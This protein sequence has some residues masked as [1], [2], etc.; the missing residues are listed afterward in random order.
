[1]SVDASSVGETMAFGPLTIH[2]DDRVLRPRPW[3]AMQS[4]WA[5]ELLS[6]APE[7]PVLELCAGAGHIG[8]LAVHGLDRHLVMVDLNPVACE[9]A[10]ANA[11]ATSSSVEVREGSMDEV[12]ETHETF[13]LVIA[14]PPWVTS[15]RTA[16]FPEDPLIAID[17]GVDGMSIAWMCLDVVSRHL[18]QDGA[19]LLQLG[20]QRQVDRLGAHLADRPGLRLVPVEVRAHEDRGVVVRLVRP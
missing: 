19:A 11:A 3:T 12:V 18:D 5:A 1:M 17:G 15:D 2:F 7:G 10:R 14:D 13:A 8:L 9:F 4:A 6:T 20:D 16:E